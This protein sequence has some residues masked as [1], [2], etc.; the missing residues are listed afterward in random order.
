M[1]SGQTA[2]SEVRNFYVDAFVLAGKDSNVVG[3]DLLSPLK[4][5]FTF[6]EGSWSSNVVVPGINTDENIDVKHNVV[7]AGYFAT[8]QI[9]LLAGRNF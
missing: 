2:S 6:H 3:P 5:A 7:G 4:A 1:E 9:P 8:M